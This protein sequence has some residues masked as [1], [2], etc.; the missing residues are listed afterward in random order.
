MYFNRSLMKTG[1]SAGLLFIS[2]LNV[3]LQYVVRL[4]CDVSNNGAEYKALVN[5]LCIAI[6]LG[7]RRLDVRGDSQLVIDQVMKNSSCHDARK[8]SM[9]PSSSPEHWLQWGQPG[10]LVF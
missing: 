6:E 10:V 8:S 3:H 5:G 2:P 4:H 1:M 7:V 9:L